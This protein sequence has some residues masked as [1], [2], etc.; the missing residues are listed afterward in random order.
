MVSSGDIITNMHEI[1]R[2][3]WGYTSFR[4]LQQDIISS[5]LEGHDTL[6]LM[7]TGGGKS[8]TFQVPA[9][10]MGGKALVVTPLISLMKDQVDNLKRRKIKAVYFHA[11]MKSQELRY[12]W[13]RLVNGNAQFLYVS[14]ERLGNQ[15]FLDELRHLDIRLIVVDEAHCIS[16]WGYDFRPSYLKIANIRKVVPGAPVLALTATATPEVTADIC[17][18]LNFR[19]DARLWKMSFSREN[20]SYIVRMT[21]TKIN[22]VLHILSH[23][24]GSAIVYVRS[25]RKC[26]EI[27]DFLENAGISSLYYHAGLDFSI[28]EQ[29]QN[30]WQSGQTR[31]MVATNAFGMGIDKPD[32][33]V[34]IHYDIPPSLEE[35]YQEAGRA[36][37]DGETSYAV[38]VASRSDKGVLHRRLKASFPDKAYIYKVYERVCNTLNLAIGE[39]YGKIMEFDLDKFCDTFKLDRKQCISALRILGQAGYLEYI[40]ETDN[41]SRVMMTCQ[42]EELYHNHQMSQLS[43]RVLNS[44]L[45]MCTGLFIDYVDLKEPQIAKHAQCTER[46]VYESLLELSRLGILSYVPRRRVPLIHVAT[47]REE[48][49]YVMIGRDVYEQRFSIME[50]RIESM[51]DYVFNNSEC[52]V[53]RML[54]YFGEENAPQCNSCDVCRSSRCNPGKQSRDIMVQILEC[55]KSHPEGMSQ[56]QLNASF[57]IKP[58]KVSEILTFLCNEGF[59]EHKNHVFRLLS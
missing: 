27:S 28:K 39:G 36:G 12:A 51:L 7:P 44:V 46:E 54:A 30:L 43:E 42:R 33:R 25:R 35:Y 47:S 37:R 20:I 55:L 15:R 2:K 10:L 16:Q 18:Q 57:G 34:V 52:R 19:E 58:G 17:R 49:K 23:T 26:R 53:K 38:I 29:R 11:G 3:H 13:E 59:I 4:P 5:V 8:I 21:D 24:S 1:L 32:V 40:E 22:E 6:G 14:P 41:G 9:L 50:R 31:V 56:T 45:R 48:T